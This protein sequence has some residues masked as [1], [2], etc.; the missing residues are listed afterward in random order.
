MCIHII[1]LND[2]EC[3]TKYQSV[4]KICEKFR[5]AERVRNPNHLTVSFQ[6]ALCWVGVNNVTKK[7]QYVS[8][9]VLRAVAKHG[10]ETM[11]R[12]I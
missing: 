3:G 7:I 8:V 4:N 6:Y 9:M 1:S 2:L 10:W 11:L 5:C 12:D